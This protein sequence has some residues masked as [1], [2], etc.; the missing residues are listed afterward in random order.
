[1]QMQKNQEATVLT[2]KEADLESY[3]CLKSRASSI[4]FVYGEEK[5]A[6]RN[7]RIYVGSTEYELMIC[8]QYKSK[9]NINLKLP[10]R[11]DK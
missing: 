11:S 8:T 5:P 3:I 6:C 1:M 9:K 4:I 7:Q 10:K 2:G